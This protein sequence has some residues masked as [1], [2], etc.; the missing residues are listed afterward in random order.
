VNINGPSVHLGLLFVLFLCC[1]FA[2]VEARR[3]YTTTVTALKTKTITTTENVDASATVNLL[4][5]ST[6]VDTS[7]TTILATETL[8]V[9]ATETVTKTAYVVPVAGKTSVAELRKRSPINL[10][11]RRR[12]YKTVTEYS[13]TTDVV[14]ETRTNVL[15]HTALS[16]V[17][18]TIVKLDKEYDTTTTTTTVST[19]TKKVLATDRA[20][21]CSESLFKEDI[22]FS[23]TVPGGIAEIASAQVGDDEAA[24]DCCISCFGLPG[25]IAWEYQPS[26]CT[27]TAIINK[28]DEQCGVPIVSFA[29]SETESL[30]GLG[31]CGVL[32]SG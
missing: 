26:N 11:H 27:V 1:S 29:G 22:S 12:P 25:C 13:T 30:G 17:L 8:E 10:D 31:P 15:T 14:T 4:E 24:V 7:L 5:T 2:S 19:K 3:R 16:K 21:L 28:P 6:D 9:V 20:Y 32:A 18:T 23:F